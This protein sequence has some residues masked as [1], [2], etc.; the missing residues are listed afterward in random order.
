MDAD[1]LR[2]SVGRSL[3]EG[4]AEV[5]VV[6]P[7]DPV[8]YLAL[9]LLKYKEN[10]ALAEERVSEGGKVAFARTIILSDLL[11]HV[12]GEGVYLIYTILERKRTQCVH[13][14]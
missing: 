13:H 14:R 3:A 1:Y 9:W 2:A 11:W 8:E 10:I 12:G 7:A 4:L 5:C 6:R